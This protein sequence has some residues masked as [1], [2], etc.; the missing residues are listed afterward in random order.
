MTAPKPQHS[1]T[2]N[3]SS[4]SCKLLASS[5]SLSSA[6]QMGKEMDVSTLEAGGVRDYADP[7]PAPL[8][9]I[10]ELGKWSLYR[11]VIAEFV[12]TL[13]F[14]YITVATVIGYKH[15]TDATASGADAACGGVGILG[16]AWAFGGMIFILVYCTAGISGPAATLACSIYMRVPLFYCIESC[17]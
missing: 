9:D 6:E 17:A 3:F 7:P 4:S 8:I 10:D 2:S 11:A 14:L 1:K 5:N 12:A 16:I 15:Q 13:L